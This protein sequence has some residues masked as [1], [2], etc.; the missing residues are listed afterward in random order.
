MSLEDAVKIGREGEGEGQFLWPNGLAFIR[1]H[2]EEADEN[3]PS[4]LLAVTD[5]NNNR[6][7]TF[8]RKGHFVRDV[9]SASL[10]GPTDV[11]QLAD[12][13]LC[14]VP[15]LGVNRRD[16]PLVRYTTF[17]L[18]VGEEGTWCT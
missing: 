10:R 14:V 11:C 3:P 7:Q 4:S 9:R 12:R 18:V 6:V 15:Y 16:E 17:S 8:D 5:F 13:R 1:N 2:R